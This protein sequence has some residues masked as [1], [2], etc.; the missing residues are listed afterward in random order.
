MAD[1]SRNKVNAN[2]EASEPASLFANDFG[3]DASFTDFALET[4]SGNVTDSSDFGPLGLDNLFPQ[5]N[6]LGDFWSA[7]P[8]CKIL[9]TSVSHGHPFG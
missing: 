4:L 7:G 9:H 5:G 8:Q 1:D 2:V 3:G 6:S